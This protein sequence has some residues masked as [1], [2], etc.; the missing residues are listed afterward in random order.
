M[1]TKLAGKRAARIQAKS[2]HFGWLKNDFNSGKTSKKIYMPNGGTLCTY[3]IGY[4]RYV[5]A[6]RN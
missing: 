3:E 2:H 1:R 5:F 4:N 6:M